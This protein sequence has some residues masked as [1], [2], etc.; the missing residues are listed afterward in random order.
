MRKEKGQY[1]P[2]IQPVVPV[3]EQV[4]EI[5]S[6]SDRPF[7]E[8]RLSREERQKLSKI[9]RKEEERKHKKQQEWEQIKRM[10]VHTYIPD[11]LKQK[12]DEIAEAED[13]SIAQVITFFLFEAV[14][15]YERREI[16]FWGYKHRSES[17]RRDWI[18][19][20]PKDT[21]R[22]EK[23]EAQKSSKRAQRS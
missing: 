9:R 7:S 13:V 17:P 6:D 1:L 3:D 2:A 21:E 4:A 20:H 15:R 11:T 22:R 19:I 14:E 18:L 16:G 12:I 8:L 10:Q 5:L 23:L